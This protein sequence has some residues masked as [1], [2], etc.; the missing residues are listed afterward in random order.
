MLERGKVKLVSYRSDE[1]R[2]LEEVGL[3]SLRTVKTLPTMTKMRGILLA[4]LFSLASA[5]TVMGQAT[6]ETEGDVEAQRA[7][8]ARAEHKAIVRRLYEEVFNTGN[9]DRADLF[10]AD[11][12]VDHDPPVPELP[13]GIEGF[14]AVLTMF[15]TAFSDLHFT[16][17]EMIVEG[18]RAVARV[19]MRGTH[20]ERFM[21]ISRTGKLVKITGIDIYRIANGRIVEHW[22]TFDRMGLMQQFG[23][24]QSGTWNKTSASSLIRESGG[25]TANG[26]G[27][28]SQ[29]RN[30]NVQLTDLNHLD[31]LKHPFQRD[32]GQVRLVA[33]LSPN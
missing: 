22:G 27:Q 19:T 15:R 26:K 30:S 20:R 18:D 13:S 6:P 3:V 33:L 17:E 25:E 1:P 2:E 16:V 23:V 8:P 14:K 4:G 10:I 12:Y 11:N 24:V 5:V 21:G 32:I 29:S 9:L 28:A 7:A 31:Q